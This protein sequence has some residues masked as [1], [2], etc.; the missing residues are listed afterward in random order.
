[1]PI[2]SLSVHVT[3]DRPTIPDSS[4]AYRVGEQIAGKMSGQLLMA[5][6]GDDGLLLGWLIGADIEGDYGH[7]LSAL[8]HYAYAAVHAVDEDTEIRTEELAALSETELDRR[9]SLPSGIPELASTKEAAEICK[10]SQQRWSEMQ[11][12]ARAGKRPNFP[13]PVVPGWYIKG[14]VEN[15]AQ[16]RRTVAGRP[17][18]SES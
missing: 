15:Y 5:T 17:A 7:R 4:A 16:T 8:E 1:M 18:R 13:E 10:V 14:Q 12:E 9:R 3:A 2:T 6:W 11:A